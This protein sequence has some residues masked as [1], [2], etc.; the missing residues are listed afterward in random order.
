MVET[1]KTFLGDEVP[2]VTKI[3]KSE[4][5]SPFLILISTL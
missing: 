1:L 2:V 3:S 4:G 5:G